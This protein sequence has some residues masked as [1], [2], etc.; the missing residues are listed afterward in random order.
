MRWISDRITITLVGRDEDLM[1]MTF[2]AKPT[3]ALEL[4]MKPY[5][6]RCR[7]AIDDLTFKFRGLAVHS[8][9]TVSQVGVTKA[10]CVFTVTHAQ[11]Q[12]SILYNSQV[13][14]LAIK[15]YDDRLGIVL[16]TCRNSPLHGPLSEF[17]VKNK[18][19]FDSA[20]WFFQGNQI[21]DLKATPAQ[22]FMQNGAQ[23]MLTAKASPMVIEVIYPG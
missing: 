17:A 23:I 10:D 11:I 12:I 8:R 15:R 4:L 5:A 6:E 14:P 18:V 1:E 22:L 7:L 9:Q 2:I 16:T 21:N 3:A 19:D 13:S 20:K